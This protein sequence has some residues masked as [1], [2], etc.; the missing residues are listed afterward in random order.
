LQ[1][2]A[3]T[4]TKLPQDGHSRNRDSLQTGQ[5]C[6]E[7][8]TAEAHDGQDRSVALPHDGQKRALTSMVDPQ[9]GHV[10]IERPRTMDFRSD[11]GSSRGHL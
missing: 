6:Q 3:V 1:N 7:S 8:S 11:I 10:R 5:K 2:R 9:V 4:D